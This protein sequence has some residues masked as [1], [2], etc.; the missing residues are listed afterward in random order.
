MYTSFGLE[1]EALLIMH[2]YSVLISKKKKEL[3]ALLGFIQF[4]FFFL[5]SNKKFIASKII[6]SQT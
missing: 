1:L 5:I 3:E 6:S 2:T 4:F